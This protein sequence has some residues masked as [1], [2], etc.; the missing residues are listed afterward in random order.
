MQVQCKR[1]LPKFYL[2][3]GKEFGVIFYLEVL[4]MHHQICLLK[5]HPLV[6]TMVASSNTF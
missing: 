1:L 6:E 5:Y 2:K 3:A 4:L